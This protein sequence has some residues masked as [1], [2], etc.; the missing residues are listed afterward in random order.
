MSTLYNYM[1]FAFHK[2]FY[3]PVD[4]VHLQLE[5]IRCLPENA[6]CHSAHM[7]QAHSAFLPKPYLALG[8]TLQK[9]Q[10]VEY[11]PTKDCFCSLLTVVYVFILALSDVF[12]P[13][14]FLTAVD[15]F[16]EVN[17]IPWNALADRLP[18]WWL[19]RC[20][21]ALC[22]LENGNVRLHLVFVDLWLFFFPWL[23]WSNLGTVWR[24]RADILGKK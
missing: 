21:G 4:C 6:F 8:N 15:V 9:I 22:I 3:A 14:S 17:C 11:S 24:L 23:N 1:G 16:G 19:Q 10:K 7:L 5:H 13:C 12:H 2:L 18:L 20:V